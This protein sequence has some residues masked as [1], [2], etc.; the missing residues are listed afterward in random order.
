VNRRL[1]VVLRIVKAWLSGARPRHADGIARRHIAGLLCV[2]CWI[3]SS[4]SATPQPPPAASPVPAAIA[5]GQTGKFKPPSLQVGPGFDPIKL[6]VILTPFARVALAA[7]AAR[8]T[9]RPFTDQDV[10]PQMLDPLVQVIAWPYEVPG[11]GDP[12][13]RICDVNHI[14]I[15]PKGGQPIQPTST[16]P[17]L[18]VL[19]NLFGA[20]VGVRGLVATFP[21]DAFTA[22]AEI[23]VVYDKANWGWGKP[24]HR[25]KLKAKDLGAWR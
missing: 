18:A 20:Q 3:A 9:Y 6:G 10:T 24:E 14:V 11:A 7:Q 4:I 25:M 19:Q 12:M 2:G 23:V 5:A 8:E 15:I 1:F 21:R 16:T 22:D 17:D 13:Q